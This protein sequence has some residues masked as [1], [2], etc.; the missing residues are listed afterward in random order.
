MGV[1]ADGRMYR[2]RGLSTFEDVTDRYGLG[3]AR[4]LGATTLGEG[5]V[6]FLLGGEIAIAD[7]AHVTRYA[8]APSA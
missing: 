8:S 2:L 5:Y 1:S 7:G 4:V 3:T 6:G